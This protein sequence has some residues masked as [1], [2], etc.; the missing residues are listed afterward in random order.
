MSPAVSG[1]LTF[2]L[3]DIGP[4]IHKQDRERRPFDLLSD[5]VAVERVVQDGP[6]HLIF[7]DIQNFLKFFVA[8]FWIGTREDFLEPLIERLR[9]FP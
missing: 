2:D 4:E 1:R 9:R 7:K 3:Q 6:R 8:Y 5:R